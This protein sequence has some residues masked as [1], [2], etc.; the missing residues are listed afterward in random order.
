M[1]H[2]GAND[3]DPAQWPELSADLG[4]ARSQA[5]S[6]MLDTQRASYEGRVL[7]LD[8]QLEQI[9]SRMT[10][11]EDLLTAGAQDVPEK[12]TERL[13]EIDQ[14]LEASKAHFEDIT[15][16]TSSTEQ[17]RDAQATEVDRLST[18]LN[19]TAARVTE[20]ANAVEVERTNQETFQQANIERL[21]GHAS[22]LSTVEHSVAE[23][24]SRLERTDL[25]IVSARQSAAEAIE[26]SAHAHS[27]RISTAEDSLA[28]S[29]GRIEFLANRFEEQTEI[30]DQ[31]SQSIQFLES[32]AAALETAHDTH[33]A[34]IVE[35]VNLAHSRLNENSTRIEESFTELASL[36]SST[37]SDRDA[38]ADA[39]SQL[40]NAID[41]KLK[42]QA[43]RQNVILTTIDSATETFEERTRQ[44][45]SLLETHSDILEATAEL[46]TEH[47]GM[48]VSNEESIANIGDLVSKNDAAIGDLNESLAKTDDRAIRSSQV[49]EAAMASL[50]TRF[51][52]T[53]DST[54]A[55]HDQLETQVHGLAPM[56]DTNQA[57]LDAVNDW[58]TIVDGRVIEIQDNCATTQ[59]Q[60]EAVNDWVTDVDGRSDR[61]EQRTADLEEHYVETRARLEALADTQQSQPNPDEVVSVS[62]FD[63]LAPRLDDHDQQIQAVN[64][65]SILVDERISEIGERVDTGYTKFEGIN[66]QAKDLERRYLEMQ[67]RLDETNQELANIAAETERLANTPTPTPTSENGAAADPE[68][69]SELR[70]FMV[71]RIDS[72]EDRIDRRLT[73][74][75]SNNGS[76]E[77]I[78]SLERAVA[79]A[80]E[81]A[82]EAHAFSENLRLLQTDLVQAIRAETSQQA[83]RIAE[84][85]AQLAARR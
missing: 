2:E 26:Q 63:G 10:S 67:A 31:I 54:K 29:S 35:H 17:A 81:R 3:E 78:E 48:A 56:V 58:V 68:A 20:L 39:I 34:E 7:E 64:D 18:S 46:L 15:S 12:L 24:N 85:E 45:S 61:I 76:S 83:Q 72:A 30:Q 33:T 49:V 25:G 82:R 16:R 27:V 40:E 14:Q 51:G 1:N 4:N 5:R 47:R 69:N 77:R 84:L 66:Q 73:A 43:E 13:E 6:I 60:I 9:R 32:R 37:D 55:D 75:E 70:Q 50:E 53:F 22:Q 71:Y 21:E 23:L 36:R 38:A 42:V 19:E 57:R 52:T 11:L 41:K 80:E 44:N 79:Q 74:I 62:Q 8:A 28:A 59:T 65:W